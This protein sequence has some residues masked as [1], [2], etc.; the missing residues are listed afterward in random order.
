MRVPEVTFVPRRIASAAA[1]AQHV[2]MRDHLRGLLA[3]LNLALLLTWSAVA[4]SLRAESEAVQLPAWT[5]MLAFL[6][7]SLLVDLPQLTLRAR[8]LLLAVEAV[9]AL[10]LVWLAPRG[11]TTP[12]LLVVLAA[13]LSMLWPL[14]RT[15]LAVLII[16]AVFFLLLW[17]S[18]HPAPFLIVL[19]YSGFQGFAL[20]IGQYATTASQ[21]RDRLALVN[22]DLLATR[23][24][25]AD[26]ARDSERLRMARDLHDVAGHKLTAITLNLRALTDEP[27]LAGREEI[28]VAH[29]LSQELLGDIRGVVQAMR[30]S[31]GLDLETAL[32]ALAAAMPRPALRL[33]VD[34]ELR[35][36]DP[37]QAETVLRL[38]QEA[39]TNAARHAGADILHVH[40]DRDGDHMRLRI[41]DDGRVRG[42]VSE[43]NGIAGMRERLAALHG[44][45]DLGRTPRG[46]LRIEARMPA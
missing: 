22:A 16:D 11:G 4:M 7:S 29:R 21:A 17:W 34:P 30:D 35:V 42:P 19:I 28:R 18:Q 45:L 37:A 39:L 14:R 46:G 12:V 9:S 1:R 25:L 2:A 13:Q 10:G 33:Q 41:E 44:S 38:V 20:L 24:L 26:S 43:G 6:A 27:A 23:A 15:L 5:L 36:T 32:R 31:R 8:H 40:L 3:P